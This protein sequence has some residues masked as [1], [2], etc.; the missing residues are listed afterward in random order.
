MSRFRGH[1]RIS[2]VGATASNS[3][4]R[5]SGDDLMSKEPAAIWPPGIAYDAA[6]ARAYGK[7]MY[8]E[9]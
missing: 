4:V 7:L 5:R 6:V 2:D 3:E 9:N 1:R 8:L